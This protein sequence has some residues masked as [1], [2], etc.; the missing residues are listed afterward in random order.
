MFI[1]FPQI[2]IDRVFSLH[3]KETRIDFLPLD[4]TVLLNRER[5][6]RSEV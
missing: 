1:K 6:I 4:S 5:E 3:V 2:Q